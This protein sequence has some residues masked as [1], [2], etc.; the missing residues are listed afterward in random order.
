[1]PDDVFDRFKFTR[2]DDKEARRFTLTDEPL[3][4]LEVTVGSTSR[5][6]GR[7]SVRLSLCITRLQST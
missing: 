1:M 6:P 5:A 2:Q 3:A 4:R 7:R